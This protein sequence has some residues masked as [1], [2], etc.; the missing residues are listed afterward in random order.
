[1]AKFLL[2]M[3]GRPRLSRAL[4]LDTARALALSALSSSPARHSQP[5]TADSPVVRDTTCLRSLAHIEGRP[6]GH[7]LSIPY[8]SPAASSAIPKGRGR[9]VF[10]A[11]A[12]PGD[13]VA[14]VSSS[15]VVLLRPP[16]TTT[17]VQAQCCA[18]RPPS[19]H[20][21]RQCSLKSTSDARFMTAN[22]A[23]PLPQG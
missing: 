15:K 21:A 18:C 9:G 11:K 10:R 12:T 14:A 1:M 23:S 20:A 6:D 22:D 7:P 5:T 8:R 2:K 4:H 16:V 19:V 3:R 13:Q 17:G